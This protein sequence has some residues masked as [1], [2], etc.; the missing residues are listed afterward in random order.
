[1]KTTHQN[2]QENTKHCNAMDIHLQ[3]NR[4]STGWVCFNYRPTET[5]MTIDLYSVDNS[6]MILA[7]S[8]NKC[9][10]KELT[11]WNKYVFN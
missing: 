7:N 6:S 8:F 3:H 4:S 1:M 2:G 10:I 5:L 9:Y 11:F